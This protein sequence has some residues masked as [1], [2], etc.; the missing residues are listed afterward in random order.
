MFS[1]NIS[2]HAVIEVALR[3]NS[4]LNCVDVVFDSG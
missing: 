4:F 1:Y 2:V 3:E